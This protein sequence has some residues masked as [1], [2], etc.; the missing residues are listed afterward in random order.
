MEEF[1]VVLKDYQDIFA[2][3]L[4]AV[5]GMISTLVTTSI[6]RGRGKVKVSSSTIDFKIVE[7]E[8]NDF[9][10]LVSKDVS[11]IQEA[12]LIEFN[13]RMTF[14][15]SSELPKGIHDIKFKFIDDKGSEVLVTPKDSDYDEWNGSRW[16][17][18][19]VK[20]IEIDPRKVAQKYLYGY[21][22]ENSGLDTFKGN[23]IKHIYII[24]TENHN[25]KF[26]HKLECFEEGQ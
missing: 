2:A 1:L 4:G 6:L 11:S 5:L 16:K 17:R 7:Q 14:Y 26:I 15:N 12:N 18:E 24:G 3:I 21:I 20:V 9:G 13:F 8:Q 25:K 10:D 19:S 22:G 23:V